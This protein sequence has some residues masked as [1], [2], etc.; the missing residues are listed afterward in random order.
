[1]AICWGNVAFWNILIQILLF[2][3]TF[4]FQPTFYF[5][6]LLRI[7]FDVLH[8][9][10]SSKSTCQKY[11]VISVLFL[12]IQDKYY[13]VS[14]YLKQMTEA[15]KECCVKCRALFLVNFRS[16]YG[17]NDGFPRRLFPN[18]LIKFSTKQSARRQNIFCDEEQISSHNLIPY[19]LILHWYNW[20][21]VSDG[22]LNITDNIFSRSIHPARGH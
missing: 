6:F 8:V 17:E 4:Y 11:S 19:M 9:Y 18:S 2:V 14:F 7:C 22:T 10:Q 1:M 16:F 5:Y 20:L 12:I 13:P 15:D 3:L 21:F